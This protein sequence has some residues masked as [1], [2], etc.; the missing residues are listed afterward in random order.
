MIDGRSNRAT[1]A[2]YRALCRA[3]G[4]HGVYRGMTTMT[5][6][7]WRSVSEARWGAARRLSGQDRD[8]GFDKAPAA[9][10]VELPT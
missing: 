1:R 9:A 4:C 2:I 7:E 3:A 10:A 5:R 6:E 8:D